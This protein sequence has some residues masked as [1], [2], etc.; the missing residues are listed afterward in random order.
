M[1]NQ[2]TVLVTG[3]TGTLG[4]NFV[5]SLHTQNPDLIFDLADLRLEDLEK[6]AHETGVNIRQLIAGDMF[7]PKTE[8]YEK[9]MGS[10]ANIVIWNAAINIDLEHNRANGPQLREMQNARL[11]DRIST[12]IG[13]AGDG[14]R[15]LFIPVNSITGIFAELK[16]SAKPMAEREGIHYLPMKHDQRL[17]L[18]H[19]RHEL[20]RNGI[21]MSVLFPGS[22]QSNFTDAQKAFELSNTTGKRMRNHKGR[23][24]LVQE[25]ILEPNEITD[26]V[27]TMAINWMHGKGVP[28]DAEH[29]GNNSRKE[30]II[31]NQSDVAD[32]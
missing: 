11:E 10:N 3:A 25:R 17:I 31:L 9:A 5:K 7:D 32:L 1:H 8:A 26:A 20:E 19:S 29:D 4:S 22:F 6:L 12:L 18:E 30:W 23:A 14:V 27:A 13:Q 21:D 28:D 2:E 16:E 24:N 15:R